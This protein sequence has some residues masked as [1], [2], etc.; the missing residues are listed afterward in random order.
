MIF[1]FWAGFLMERWLLFPV[2][3]FIQKMSPKCITSAL[4][5]RRMRSIL[6]ISTFFLKVFGRRSSKKNQSCFSVVPAM[7]QKQMLVQCRKQVVIFTESKGAYLLS[8]FGISPVL[9]EIKKTKTGEKE[10]HF[11]LPKPIQT[12]LMHK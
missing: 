6:S 11:R 9:T 8:P 4:S 7:M 10:I 1:R 5:T 2:I 12:Q 3:L